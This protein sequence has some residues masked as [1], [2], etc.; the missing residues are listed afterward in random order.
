MLFLVKEE[1]DF[2]AKTRRRRGLY[3]AGQGIS[4]PRHRPGS[5]ALKKMNSGLGNGSMRCSTSRVHAVVRRNDGY[6]MNQ[7]IFVFPLR[8][9]V[10]ALEVLGP[11]AAPC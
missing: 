11:E 1:K 2:N 3:V 6:G 9:G 10:L 4:S 5:R 7:D 8:L